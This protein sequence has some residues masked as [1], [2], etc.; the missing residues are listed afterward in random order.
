[1]GTDAV[2]KLSYSHEAMIDAMVQN[3]M[4]KGWQL[5]QLF[6]VSESWLSRVRSSNAF[7]ERLR[8]RTSELVDPLLAADIEERFD[9]MVTRSLEILQEKLGEPTEQ[10]DPQLALQCAALGAKARGYGGFGAK[11][12]PAPVARDPQWL[13]RSA[14]RLR[15]LNQGVIDVVSREVPNAG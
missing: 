4:V 10:I 1:M 14:D 7:R 12:A 2:V 11:V 3:P 6:G 9:A 5:A 15:S 8:E 13:E